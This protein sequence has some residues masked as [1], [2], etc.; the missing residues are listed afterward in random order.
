MN[1]K[2]ARQFKSLLPLLFILLVLPILLVIIPQAVQYLGRAGGVPANITVSSAVI[3]PLPTPWRNLAQGG[4]E[5]NDMLADV[6]PQVRAL[7]PQ[8]IRLDHLYDGYNVVSRSGDQ[9]VYDWSRLDAAVD[10]ILAT[11]AKPFLSLSY[12]PPAISRGDIV[13]YPNSWTDW[14]AVVQA[15]V[16]HF[17][18]V[19]QKNISNVYY[20]VWN[21]P[22]LFG[23]YKTYGDKNYLTLYLHSA[24]GA[25]R[26]R[27]VRAF[28]LGGPATTAL[29]KN[30]LDTFLDFTVN[31]NLRLDFYSWHR[32]STRLDQYEEDVAAINSWLDAHPEKADLELIISEWGHN[33]EN[34]PGYDGRFSAIQTM[35]VSRA[36]MARVNRA[37]VFEIK[38]GPGETQYWGRWGLLT[39]QK[40]GTPIAKPRYSALTFLNRLGPERLSLSGEGTWVRG[41]AAQKDNTIQAL[42]VNYDPSGK[43]QEAV[44][45]TFTDLPAQ[46]FTYSRTDFLGSTR[47]LNVATT[48]AAWQTTEFF[49]PNSAA[50]LE[51]TF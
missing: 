7:A 43:H 2:F 16:E 49:T 44:P 12:M 15:T 14:E 10:S 30:W 25:A 18:G 13:D 37:F 26:A 31:N 51:L 41:I 39:H 28:K 17:S 48:S 11:G 29:Y 23:A 6:I 38:D 42:I 35:A 19:N 22:D 5:T 33:P 1:A 20:E 50:L 4:E 36:L 34:D 47:T 27:G 9:L 46:N 3:G 8:Y 45:I 40:F 32:Y 21:E 24:R